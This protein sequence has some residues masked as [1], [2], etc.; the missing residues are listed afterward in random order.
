MGELEPVGYQHLIEYLNLGAKVRP[1]E[2]PAFLNGSVNQKVRGQ[3]G[4][5]Y[6]R[7]TAVEQTLIGHVEFALRNEGVNLEVLEA[8]F[9]HLPEAEL[10]RRLSESPNSAFVRRTCFF[11]EWLTGGNLAFDKSP[12]GA[13][14]DALPEADYFTS[15]SAHTIRHPKF[16]VRDNLPGTPDFCPLVRRYALTDGPSLDELLD[17]AD[18]TLEQVTDASLYERAVHYLYLSETQSTYGIEKEKPNGS[19]GERFVQILARAGEEERITEEWLVDLQN[20]IVRDAY[21][22][23]ASY[24]TKQNWLE[25]GTGRITFFPPPPEDLQRAMQ[26]WEG[27][28]NEHPDTGGYR[29]PNVLVRAA[30]AAFG[31][32][33]LHP[34]LD[35]NGRIHRFLIHHVINGARRLKGGAIVPVSAVFLRRADEYLNVLN[36]FSRPTTRLWKYAPGEDAPHVTASPGGRPYRFFD[37]TPEVRFLHAMLVEAVR[38]ELPREL[39]WLSGFDSAF[40]Q[41]NDELNIPRPD[42]SALIRMVQSNNG[43][44]SSNKRKTFKHLPDEVIARIEDVVREAFAAASVQPDINGAS[45]SSRSRS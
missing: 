22:Q 30:C 19:K 44:L 23:E 5:W 20:V 24:R 17:E 34:F 1:L 37:A 10:L 36:G 21:A 31:F 45:H 26:G 38:T 3:N 29:C 2:A 40:E 11:W 28:I 35:G 13:Y 6:P 4:F 41:L 9:E 25:D 12:S 15:D 42:L 8:V 33:F 18:R 27:F 43:K 14:V 16:R 32:V 39:H 7:K